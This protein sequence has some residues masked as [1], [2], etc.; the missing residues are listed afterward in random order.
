[1]EN[2]TG[3]R[4]RAEPTRMLDAARALADVAEILGPVAITERAATVAPTAFGATDAAA[5]AHRTW[6]ATHAALVRYLDQTQA[7]A[8]RMSERVNSSARGYQRTDAR[9]AELYREMGL[10]A[11]STDPD[12]LAGPAGIPTVGT[13]PVAVRDWWAALSPQQ[14]ERAVR[15]HPH[16]V[17]GLDGVPVV[18]RDRAN[19]AVLA[20][21][22]AELRSE[23][24][25][26]EGSHPA[27]GG[28][29]ARL[30]DT[31]A[32][33]DRLEYRLDHPPGNLAG[34]AS[35]DGRA[36]LLR[37]NAGGDGRAVVAVGNPDTA[38]QVLTFVPGMTSSLLTVP[39]DVSRL[40]QILAAPT[41]PRGTAA[42]AWVDYDAPNDVTMVSDDGYA[43]NA[44]E[45]LS[46][47]QEGLRA[48]HVGEPSHNVLLAHSYGTTVVGHTADRAGV[49][50]DAVYLLASIGTGSQSANSFLGV[51]TGGVHV[52]SNAYD[53]AHLYAAT[54]GHSVNPTHPAFGARHLPSPTTG[55]AVEFI[56]NH[57]GYFT[58]RD[59]VTVNHI[60][61]LLTER[62]R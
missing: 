38:S 44:V 34:T 30:T 2:L 6:A 47:F 57:T 11:S 9:I 55:W 8:E 43:R 21:T 10:D 24:A 12:I 26:Y 46:R 17:G 13:E 48:S 40:D 22:L 19:R 32:A 27:R 23:Q 31:I 18:D 33:L 56:D 16:L 60:N 49:N 3:A 58:D 14:R 7:K 41:A 52:S 35:D 1:M 59:T 36:Y 37:I 15:E 5:E 4:V 61:R 25:G 45:P 20:A 54:G 39:N 62:G 28:V 53:V 51:P 29:P 42:I 50:A